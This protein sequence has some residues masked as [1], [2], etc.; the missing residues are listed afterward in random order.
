MRV[1]SSEVMGSS[2]V[3]DDKIEEGE[4]TGGM[5]EEETE[6]GRGRQHRTTALI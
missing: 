2:R 4:D 3:D 6:G 5:D 1:T